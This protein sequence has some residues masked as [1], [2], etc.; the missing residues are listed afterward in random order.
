MSRGF[1]PRPD[2]L[3]LGAVGA[4]LIAVFVAA[5]V[6]EVRPEWKRH[7]ENVR[8]IVTERMGAEA[9]A[10]VP[11]G[12]RQTW[13]PALGRV[14]RC[15]TCHTTIDWGPELAA[16]P[17]P[18]RSHPRPELLAK[19]PVESYGCTLCHGGQGWAVTMEAAH[20]RVEFWDEPLLDEAKGRRYDLPAGALLETNCNLCHRYQK[21]VEGMPLL[22]EAKA[23]VQQRKCWKCHTINGEGGTDGPDLTYEGD[24]HPSQYAFPHA[25]AKPRTALYYHLAHFADP[26]AVVP[27]SVMPK[28]V[29]EDRQR[30]AL[31]LLVL[32]W[33]KAHLP[34]A[35]MAPPD[36]R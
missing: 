4:L 12:L 22:N 35:W 15:V 19:H 26:P 23:F 31:A 27:G 2:Q 1:R 9:A 36:P 24:K 28:F 10:R 29:M 11:S 14:D 16:A 3:A 18:A 17:N 32:S 25:W 5:T 20:G 6:R 7:Q 30:T 21:N 33:R 13:I 34:A 8:R